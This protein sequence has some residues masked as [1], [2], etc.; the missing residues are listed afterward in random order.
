LY[1]CKACMCKALSSG[2]LTMAGASAIVKGKAFWVG[3]G[4]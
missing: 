3:S 4:G 1:K 2:D